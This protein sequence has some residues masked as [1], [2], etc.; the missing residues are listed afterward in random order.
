M[1]IILESL[2]DKFKMLISLLFETLAC[3]T[4]P[5]YEKL[6]DDPYVNF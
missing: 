2:Y 1:Y 3:R 4:P 5:E 6:P